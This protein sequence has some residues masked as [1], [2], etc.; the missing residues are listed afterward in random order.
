MEKS[1]SW[2]QR[3]KSA[4]SSPHSAS[5]G[6]GAFSAMPSTNGSGEAPLGPNEP[7]PM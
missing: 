6:G 3:A 4:A 5:A 2:L 1:L 7:A